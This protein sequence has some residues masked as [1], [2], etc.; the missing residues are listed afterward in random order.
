[1]SKTF[2][3][4]VASQSPTRRSDCGAANSVPP[5]LGTCAVGM[6]GCGAVWHVDEVFIKIRGQF[7]YFW[8]VVDQDGDVIDILVTRK[9]DRRAA[10]RFFRKALN[11]D[12]AVD[13]L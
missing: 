7:H 3:P 4:S 5:L 13:P 8:R 1:M 11:L 9:R 12:S 10:K 2:S 6:A